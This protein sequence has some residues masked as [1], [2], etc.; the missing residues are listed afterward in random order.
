MNP[1]DRNR[2]VLGRTLDALKTRKKDLERLLKYGE[3]RQGNVRIQMQTAQ[4]IATVAEEIAA[5]EDVMKRRAHCWKCHRDVDHV[6]AGDHQNA[7]MCSDC[8]A[9]TYEATRFG[10][11]P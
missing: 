6:L 2:N 9:E 1:I 4:D 7:G 3:D 8:S 11:N 10:A 5:L